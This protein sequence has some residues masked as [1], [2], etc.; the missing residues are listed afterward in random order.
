MLRQFETRTVTTADGRARSNDE[1]QASPVRDLN[2]VHEVHRIN[3]DPSDPMPAPRRDSVGLSPIEALQRL[4]CICAGLKANAGD[5]FTILLGSDAEI[6]RFKGAVQNRFLKIA[7]VEDL[8]AALALGVE[9][10]CFD[11]G[12]RYGVCGEVQTYLLTQAGITKG[13][14]KESN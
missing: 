8:K 11:L 4:I 14:L 2:L 13:E 7:A 6:R 1:E 9:R 3:H 5:G 10:G 12:K